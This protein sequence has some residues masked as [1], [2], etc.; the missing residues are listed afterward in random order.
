MGRHSIPRIPT[1]PGPLLARIAAA[2]V[3]V[4]AGVAA[5]SSDVAVAGNVTPAAA[6]AGGTQIALDTY[7]RSLS[8]TLGRA[9]AGGA[10]TVDGSA[11]VR[12]TGT[13][14]ELTK[15][16]P[17]RS[18]TFLLPAATATDT[19]LDLAIV[20]PSA[21]VTGGPLYVAGLL[22]S[23]A[24]GHDAYRSLVKINHGAVTLQIGRTGA[25]T[26][27]LARK[28]MT[29][30][31]VAGRVLYLR[32]SVT[33]TV[34][35]KLSARAWLA[36]QPVPA[37]AQVSAT[38]TAADPIV[39]SGSVGVF[40]YESTAGVTTSVAITGLQA[41]RLGGA[42]R[43]PA[44][45]AAPGPT[46]TGVPDGTALTRRNGDWTVSAPG[47]YSGLD[48]HGFVRVTASNVTIKNSI[49][50]GG[51]ARNDIGV[52]NV[53]YGTHDVVIEDSEIVPEYPS[54]Y[55]DGVTG[56]GYTLRNVDIHGTVDGAKI[57]GDNT[58]ITQSWIHGLRHYASV[59]DQAGA[60]SHN[61]DV[62]VL[63]GRNLMISG[64]TLADA[65]NAALQVT[66]TRGPVAGLTFTGNWA[67][68]GA[69]TVNLQDR[70]LSSMSQINLTG[71]RFG[72]TSRYGC[73]ITSYPGVSFGLSGNTW[74]DG[75]GPVTVVRQV[76]G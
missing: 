9:D 23:S 20:V 22:R 36:G 6:P 11:G 44:A 55:I 18:G 59:A 63:G 60:G 51:V 56:W 70:P 38:D 19:T 68:Y 26:T 49:L 25:R 2:A 32:G 46:N 14:A 34:Q 47:V 30:R 1:A 75:T 74:T 52:V 41:W 69:C 53:V 62:Q 66:Q 37:G 13:A 45:T 4:V 33:G 57:F 67:G 27:T 17:G 42:T 7:S 54:G 8:G 28:A 61:D 71:N 3:L 72:R 10:Y 73:A 24:H 50:R 29:W 43:T 39:R 40:A 15:I 31:A 16:A 64:N 48:V 12:V 35:P 65:T 58:T 5:V 76:S 21:A